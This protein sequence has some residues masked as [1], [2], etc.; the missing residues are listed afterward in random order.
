M[1]VRS[2]PESLK[3]VGP[4]WYSLVL[5]WSGLALAWHRAVPLMGPQADYLAGAAAV[6]A[7]AVFAVVTLAIGLRMR[8]HPGALA[9]DLAHPVRHPFAAAFPISLLLLSLL[10]LTLVGGPVAAAVAIWPWALG[11]VLQF[12]ATAWVLS[13]MLRDRLAWPAITPILFIPVVGNVLVPLPALLLGLPD[14]AWFFFAIGAFFWPLLT[15][16]MF[17]RVGQLAVPDRIAPSWMILAAPPAIVGI[18]LMALGV[19]AEGGLAMLGLA[20]LFVVVALLKLLRTPATGFSVAW[21]ALSFPLAAAVTLVEALA[22]GRPLLRFPAIAA[23]AA[24]TLTIL[25]LSS[26]TWRGLRAGTL[27]APEPVAMIQPAS[28]GG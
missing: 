15:T 17:V 3:F 25:W 13:R 27:L 5:G 11:A 9:E 21:W 14:V 8:S 20:L 24:V 16:L 18:D 4:Q 2:L 1:S 7:A 22:A 12:V 28:T 10:L 6:V 23:L 19:P 26:A